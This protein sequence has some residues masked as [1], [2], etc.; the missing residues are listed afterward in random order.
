[1]A[2]LTDSGFEILRLPEVVSTLRQRGV[3]A[4]QDLTSPGDT[5]DT[6]DSSSIGRMIGIVSDPLS[7]LWEVAQQTYTAFT[8]NG[9]TGISLDNIV[10]LSGVSPR[11]ENTFTTSQVIVKGS[12]GTRIVKDSV[13]GS[14]TTSNQF[15]I[16]S[17]IEL[18]TSSCISIEIAIQDTTSSLTYNLSFTG[19]S[20]S[21]SVTYTAQISD[22]PDVILLGIKTLLDSN[23][24]YLSSEINESVLRVSTVDIFAPMTFNTS[25]NLGVIN[26]SKM[27]DVVA[28]EAGP[29]TQPVNTIN[30]ILTPVLGWESVY[31]PTEAIPG[32]FRETDEELRERFRRTRFDRASNIVEAIYSALFRLDSVK[33]VYIDDNDTD[34]TNANGTPGHSFLVLVDGGT[35]EDIARAIWDNRGA[36]VKSFGNTSITIKDKYG[37]P[38]E[39][40]FSRPTPKD[41]YVQISLTTD[42]KFPQDGQDLIKTA[43]SDYLSSLTIGQDVIYSRLYTPINSVPGHQ[44][45]SLLIGL[46]NPA[47]GT[48]NIQIAFDQIGRILP[49]NITF[50]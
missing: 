39:I 25:S 40:Q 13:I 4:F 35:S 44:V 17:D 10:A 31:N 36:G 12:T 41:I 32:R 24:S 15:S 3:D 14:T 18:N 50:I 7:D 6:S 16:T 5:V 33:Q 2:G 34:V 9:A 19:A 22:T 8:V 47:D 30:R 11:L 45:N 46:N 42:E 43:L 49:E 48:E 29:L 21:G 38:R 27:G 23:Y 28:T 37:Y 26:V 20:N 1:M